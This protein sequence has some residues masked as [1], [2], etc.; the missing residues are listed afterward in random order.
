MSRP[1]ILDKLKKL[2]ALSKSPE[3]HEAANAAAAAQRIML[4]HKIQEAD[5]EIGGDDDL[6]EPIA[7]FT[8]ERRAVTWKTYLLTGVARA[9]SCECYRA[10][11][12]NR[13]SR[14]LTG[15]K[16]L[17]VVGTNTDVQA[18]VYIYRYLCMEINRLTRENGY[19]K[20]GIHTN[21][22]KLGVVQ[23]INATL[24]KQREILRRSSETALTIIDKGA[25]QVSDYMKRLELTEAPEPTGNALAFVKGQIAGT[26]VTL[27]GKEQRQLGAE[28]ARLKSS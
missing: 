4:E 25:E 13:E 26:S 28:P 15:K 21:S 18:V 11:T 14:K 2:L 17:H 7:D 6:V 22:F 10:Q 16:H 9:N 1:K 20:N 24:R 5:L 3:A 27:P 12:V 19:E 8:V 23:M